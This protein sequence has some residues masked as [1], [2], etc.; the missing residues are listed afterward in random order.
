MVDTLLTV[1]MLHA[2][3]FDGYASV[4][5]VSNDTD[6]V[7]PL[8]HVAEIAVGARTVLLMSERWEQGVLDMLQDV[9]VLVIGVEGV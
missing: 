2:L 3:H 7:P 1:D 6:F 4:G 9:G 5:L 8:L